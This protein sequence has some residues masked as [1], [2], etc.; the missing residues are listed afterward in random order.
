MPSL[1]V[2]K[3]TGQ[4]GKQLAK[5]SSVVT[6]IDHLGK[7]HWG[8]GAAERWRSPAHGGRRSRQT[9]VGES[10]ELTGAKRQER[11]GV[12]SLRSPF[13]HGS[14]RR[15]GVGLAFRPAMY[16]S[17]LTDWLHPTAAASKRSRPSC[18]VAARLNTYYR[19]LPTEPR[20]I[21]D[22]ASP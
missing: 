2:L 19:T 3:S 15:L 10:D 1:N 20:R 17:K 7:D 5:D 12:A 14:V 18:R 21:L 8:S 11:R 16:P 22:Q 9:P 13:D 6:L 4:E